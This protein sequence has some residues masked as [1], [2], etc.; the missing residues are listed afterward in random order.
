MLRSIAIAVTLASAAVAAPQ[1]TPSA[2]K[3]AAPAPIAQD[4]PS[5]PQPAGARL[6]AQLAQELRAG[7][8]ATGVN[9]A[10]GQGTEDVNG[11][12]PEVSAEVKRFPEYLPK[13]PPFK[14]S[15]RLDGSSSM[16]GLLGALGRSYESVYP[17]VK[18]EVKQGGS[19]SGLAALRAGT[20][21]MAAV[22]RDLTQAEVAE[23]EAATGLKVFQVPVALDAV[24]VF[25]NRSNVLPTITR[26]QLNGIFS[27][28]HSLTK[29]PILRWS[30]LDPKSPLGDQM[31]PIY[32]LSISHGT[33]QEFMRWAMPDEGLQ[34]ITR[35]EEV[36]PSAVVNACCAYR[37]A[38]GLAGY[39]NRQP[40]ARMLPVSPGTGQAAVAPSF[41]TIRDRSYPMW[42]PLNLVVLAKDEASVPP[43]CMDF[44]R[45]VWSESGQDTVA[46]LKA[47]VTDLDRPPALMRD[48]VQR[49]Y[50]ANPAPASA[51]AR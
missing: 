11:Y 3:P 4:K 19:S 39:A 13:V 20:C 48:S 23:I 14:G 35:R 47:V 36:S 28:T 42:R 7:G 9:V 49:P 40:R 45:F 17:D 18:V 22:S 5:K 8:G 6:E 50:T 33:M 15:L 46:T 12:T 34:T 31:M 10:I 21:D 24:C 30:D 44:L 27:I 1:G 2:A 16:A 43:M 32:M 41:R 26:E 29:D 51:P 25:V 38:I 37:T